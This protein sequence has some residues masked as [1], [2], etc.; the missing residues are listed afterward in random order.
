MHLHRLK[1]EFREHRIQLILWAL[2]LIGLSY[3]AL[4]FWN[5]D[6]KIDPLTGR[7]N[8]TV[9]ELM[10]LLMFPLILFPFV[11]TISS[12]RRDNL[13]DPRAF[14]NTRPI[15]P[16]TLHITKFLFLHL[17]LTLPA[18]LCT[19]IV[20]FN[21]VSLGTSLILTT[22]TTLWC[23]T[24][25]HLSGLAAL[26][27]HSLS[28]LF[29]IPALG[30]AG[31]M[32]TAFIVT[33]LRSHYQSFNP[34]QF[35]MNLL[36]TLAILLVLFAIAGTFLIKKPQLK[37]PLW[38]PLLI[39]ALIF[40]LITSSWAPAFSTAT[41]TVKLHA[42][43]PITTFSTSSTKHNH[44]HL[45]RLNFPL[46]QLLTDTER[47]PIDLLSSE[48]SIDPG[49]LS[50]SGADVAIKEWSSGFENLPIEKNLEAITKQSGHNSH[51]RISL[52]IKIPHQ[53]PVSTTPEYRDLPRKNITVRGEIELL[54]VSFE[55]F[56]V[57]EDDQKFETKSSGV[58]FSYL[59]PS[60]RS[61]GSSEMIK[62]FSLPLASSDLL[63]SNQQQPK[64]ML[65][66]RHR[67]NGQWFALSEKS[68]SSRG[69]LFGRLR[70]NKFSHINDSNMVNHYWEHRLQ[71][72][73]PDFPDFEDWRKEADL[74][75]LP[76]HLFQTIKVPFEI[77]IAV[78]DLKT[79]QERLNETQN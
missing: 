79:F 66:L 32:L 7:A 52:S 68:G 45:Y 57:I 51:F 24:A 55:D 76:P 41:K 38:A 59:P 15:R 74:L 36:I 8:D 43:E 4:S 30:S 71:R 16:K 34:G 42:P 78:P 77:T 18:A 21:A 75:I 6:V 23:A 29:L 35:E 17:V 31:L 47:H 19:F 14:W 40:T 11:I 20:S 70:S 37:F 61:S 53:H 10:S 73:S 44:Q 67:V 39:G 2:T 69:N 26:H 48:V 49:S 50:L 60:R 72:A 5:S 22:E 63:R 13:K 3:G 46:G 56:L 65:I 9:T 28:K 33:N 1:L 27:N 54:T 25:I 12:F 64:S 62:T 58:K